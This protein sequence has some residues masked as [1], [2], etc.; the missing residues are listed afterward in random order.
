M[1]QHKWWKKRPFM[2]GDCIKFSPWLAVNYTVRY[3]SITWTTTFCSSLPCVRSHPTSVPYKRIYHCLKGQR[4]MLLFPSTAALGASAL[5]DGM[6]LYLVS[7][8]SHKPCLFLHLHYKL[9]GCR[10]CSQHHGC[11]RLSDVDSLSYSSSVDSLPFSF[12][13]VHRENGVFYTA[14]CRKIYTM[15]TINSEFQVRL[16]TDQWIHTLP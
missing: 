14:N 8:S 11:K 4:A 16:H 2:K 15:H 7:A 3:E 10:V 12:I 6:W 9:Q 13:Y 1:Q 5:K